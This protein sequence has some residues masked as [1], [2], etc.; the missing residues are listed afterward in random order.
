M[1]TTSFQIEHAGGSV[2][3]RRLL[4]CA[5]ILAAAAA[6]APLLAK[7]FA[8]LWAA[9]HYQ[10]FPFV[11]AAFAWL[12][13]DRLKG[14]VPRETRGAAWNVAAVTLVAFA[15]LLLLQAYRSTSPWLAFL[16]LILLVGAFFAA[17]SSILR[18]PGLWM[19]WLLLWVI[20]PL[21][22]NRDEQLITALQRVSSRTSSLMLDLLGVPHLMEGNTLILQTKQFFVDDACSGIISLLSVVAC[23][24]IYS[25]WRKHSLIHLMALVLVGVCWAT[26]MNTVRIGLIAVAY[27]YWNI[28]WSA[29]APHE[30]LS[31][32]IFLITFLALLS[33]DAIL[34][35]VFAPIG[36]A[37]K[38]LYGEPPVLGRRLVNVWDQAIAESPEQELLDDE[39]E[40]VEAASPANAWR[41][42][43]FNATRAPLALFI[44][45]IPAVW[46]GL[47]ATTASIAGPSNQAEACI[48]RALAIDAEV[49]PPAIGDL[50]RSD[51]QHYERDRDNILG[52]YSRTFE[53]RDSHGES[54]LVSCDF[55][56]LGGWHELTV[57]YRGIGWELASRSTPTDQPAKDGKP[58]P[59]LEADFTKPDGSRAYLTACAF[60]EY[61][62]PIDLPSFSLKEDAWR[63]LTNT[64]DAQSSDVAF[65]VQVFLVKSQ[66]PTD[67]DRQR[68]RDLLGKARELFRARIAEVK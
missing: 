27:H 67:N 63:A 42:L 52:N 19:T 39:P 31:L 53:Y 20:L 37:W 36:A 26:V 32:G 7:F 45:V 49:L 60:N 43:P 68:A 46:Y 17:V 56:Y 65:Q 29:G 54:Y 15:W 55:P 34:S 44:F 5:G 16:S 4:A 58:W 51:F 30:L 9:P 35:T 22:L 62:Q 23:A 33:S 38:E 28:D 12:A 25:V 11:L 8:H 14:G 10:H 59:R 21:P 64:R 18:A 3:A 48:K 50:Q 24:A 41:S 40:A 57:C 2:A 66:P 13:F 61:G 47:F 1:S 6:Y